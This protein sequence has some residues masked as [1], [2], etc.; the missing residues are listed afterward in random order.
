MPK[1]SGRG[2]G[3]C[4]NKQN[5]VGPATDSLDHKARACYLPHGLLY[6]ELLHTISMYSLL[7]PLSTLLNV[8][9]TWSIKA[10]IILKQNMDVLCLLINS[11]ASL[12]P[13]WINVLGS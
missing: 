6:N 7:V 13:Q 10:Y 1:A 9:C 5:S 3:V 8:L 12:K 2:Q 4:L 11:C